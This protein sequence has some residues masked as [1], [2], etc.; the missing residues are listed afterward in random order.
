[1][2]SAPEHA[3]LVI[4]RCATLGRETRA[5]LA[6]QWIDRCVRV[7]AAAALERVGHLI[8]AERHASRR[9]GC[10]T[11]PQKLETDW[12]RARK[13]HRSSRNFAR[14]VA[15]AHGNRT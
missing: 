14:W 12:R 2:S 7:H 10:S 13:K 6:H 9:S 4:G 3:E 15:V 8:D 1:M 5:R 11:R